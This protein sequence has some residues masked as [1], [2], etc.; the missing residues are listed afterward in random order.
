[1]ETDDIGE[2]VDVRKRLLAATILCFMFLCVET[3]GA[4]M[5]GSLALLSDAVHLFADLASLVVALGAN[6]L[7]SLPASQ[8]YTYGT[9]R[10]CIPRQ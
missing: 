2:L 7:A 1:M 4:F 3:A 8:T 10:P 6:H 5:A 9:S